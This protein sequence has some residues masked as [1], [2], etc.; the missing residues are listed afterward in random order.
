MSLLTIYHFST[1]PF[2]RT[3]RICLQEKHQD[4]DLINENI[5]EHREEFLRINPAGITPV[6]VIDNHLLVRGIKPIVEFIEEVC[7][8]PEL[9]PGNPEVRA[10]IR[11]LFDWFND[12]FYSEVTKYILSEK[13][14]RII[15]GDGSPNSSAIRAAKKNI[16]YHLD[17]LHY[18][19]N[20]N[21]Y[22]CGERITIADCAAA[23]QLSVL[24]L[25]GDVPWNHSQKVKS[26]YSLMKSRPSV[27][28]ILYDEV[29]GITPPKHYANPDF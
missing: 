19:L 7:K 20:N 8:E 21:T 16:V 25:V 10:H 5:W 29:N 4:F 15:T 3:A 27:S 28:A 11:Y 24:D 18:L 12:K 13:I 23:A 17:Y 1:C 22:L 26:W 6:L 9:I 14:I 2:S